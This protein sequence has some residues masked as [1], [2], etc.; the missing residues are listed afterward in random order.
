[1]DGVRHYAVTNKQTV[2]YPGMKHPLRL[3]RKGDEQN[4]HGRFARD[5]PFYAEESH[6]RFVR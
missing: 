6:F 1:M 2:V 4:V 3:K 5:A